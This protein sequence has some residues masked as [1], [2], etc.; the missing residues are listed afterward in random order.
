[1]VLGTG[2][3]RPEPRAR[4]SGTPRHRFLLEL[5]SDTSS[6][7]DLAAFAEELGQAAGFD[8]RSRGH[9]H[10]ALEEVAMNL[11]MHGRPPTGRFQVRATL[12]ASRLV[13]EVL[14]GGPPFDFEQASSA[15]RGAPSED[16]PVGGVGLYLVRSVMDEVHYEP[17]TLEGNRMILVKHRPDRS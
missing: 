2:E 6:L 7:S 13:L 3:F 17:G 1:M 11:I 14:D 10:L 9:L 15:Y 8:E 16:G 4:P 5:T 12:D